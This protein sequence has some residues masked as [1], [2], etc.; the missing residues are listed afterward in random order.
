MSHKLRTLAEDVGS[1]P[2]THMI[3]HNHLVLE[4][5]ILSSDNCGYNTCILYTDIHADKT[6]TWNKISKQFN[7]LDGL[8]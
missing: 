6:H 2:S 1:V 3:A 4:D 8:V 7:I 5:L